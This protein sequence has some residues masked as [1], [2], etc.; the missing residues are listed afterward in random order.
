VLQPKK[1]SPINSEQCR[2]HLPPAAIDV[3]AENLRT[4]FPSHNNN[5]DD[6]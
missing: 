5:N 6:S 2:K 3:N 4:S 1:K